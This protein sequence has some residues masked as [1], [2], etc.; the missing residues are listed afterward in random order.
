MAKKPEGK[1]K[2]THLF[3]KM[4]AEQLVAAGGKNLKK[5]LS[6]IQIVTG[7][8]ADWKVP[9]MV[10]SIASTLV[11]GV[12]LMKQWNYAA[13]G[14]N[15]TND[16]IKFLELNGS[17]KKKGIVQGGMLQVPMTTTAATMQIVAR[18]LNI[19]NRGIEEKVQHEESRRKEEE[20]AEKEKEKHKSKP[21]LCYD[22]PKRVVGKPA[23]TS[24]V[25]MKKDKKKPKRVMAEMKEAAVAQQ[26]Q[27]HEESEME[28]A[29]APAGM[30]KMEDPIDTRAM[31]MDKPA[32]VIEP[33]QPPRP[34]R[35]RGSQ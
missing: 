33:Y 23:G 22:A 6:R 11:M 5:G 2:N 27:E 30:P 18:V 34:M 21:K 35:P 32:P 31:M 3:N 28:E 9:V 8:G 24:V 17:T 19:I 4:D 20:A 29:E 12:V 10:F 14:R 26:E 15:V 16:V 7:G 25:P 13:V 1:K